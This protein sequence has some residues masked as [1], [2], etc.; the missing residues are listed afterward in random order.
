MLTN[1]SKD[2]GV[3]T[4][5]LKQDGYQQFISVLNTMDSC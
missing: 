3:M 1:F 5:M 2:S 4:V